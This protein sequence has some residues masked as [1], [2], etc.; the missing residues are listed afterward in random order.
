MSGSQ[1]K[2]KLC[3][4]VFRGRSISF[5]PLV[6]LTN[7]FALMSAMLRQCAV[8]MFDQGWFKVRVRI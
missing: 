3:M 2:I 4:A 8:L 1:S 7:N 6:G 5:E